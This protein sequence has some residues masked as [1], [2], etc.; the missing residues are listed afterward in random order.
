[1]KENSQHYSALYLRWRVF[2]TSA[3][4]NLHTSGP[5]PEPQY[6]SISL[7]YNKVCVNDQI[8]YSQW[9]MLS[10]HSTTYI[11]FIFIYVTKRWRKS[12]SS[13]RKLI[14]LDIVR[15]TKPN[16]INLEKITND[17]ARDIY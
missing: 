14:N 1:M 12:Q 3:G 17:I 2:L 13:A 16:E 5:E 4:V 6:S 11:T 8:N 15:K 10:V 9:L 7:T